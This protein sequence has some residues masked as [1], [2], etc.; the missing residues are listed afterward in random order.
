MGHLGLNGTRL[1]VVLEVA[2]VVERFLRYDRVSGG[3]LLR[4]RV[5]LIRSWET[6]P[7]ASARSNQV[8][9]RVFSLCVHVGEGISLLSSVLYSHLC[10]KEKLFGQ[11]GQPIC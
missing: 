7:K 10:Q 8:Q 11:R 5:N 3:R 9:C 2:T 4:A 6:D 1:E